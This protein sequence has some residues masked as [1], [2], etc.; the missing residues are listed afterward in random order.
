MTKKEKYSKENLEKIISES[1]SIKDVLKKMNLRIA[2]GNYKIFH[3]YVGL[4]KL[5]IAHFDDKSKVYKKTLGIS[6][7]KRK[8]DLKD[9]LIEESDYC[10]THLKE[11]LYKENLKKRSCELCGQGEVWNGKKISLIIDHINGVYNDNRLENLRIVCP[12]CNATLPTHCGKQRKYINKCIDCN[13]VINKKSKKCH[14]CCNKD[15][16]LNRRIT[17]RPSH[18]ELKHEIKI[19][20]Y[21]ATGRKYGVS[22]NTI[23]KWIKNYD[24]R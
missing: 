24:K 5:N 4:Y 8:K 19:S 1:I 2:G 9:I 3:K 11:R 7:V 13:K 16:G 14:N 17:N 6:N 21:S 15:L 22:D 23:R 12:N 10:R 18:E 20:G